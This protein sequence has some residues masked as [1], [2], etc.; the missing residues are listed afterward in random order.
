MKVT[1]FALI[2]TVAMLGLAAPARAQEAQAPAGQEAD[3]M[4]SDIVV[5][6]TRRGTALQNTPLAV[7]ALSGESL[8]QA[9]ITT[10][11]DLV[12]VA[13]TVQVA[14]VNNIPQIYIRGIGLQNTTIGSDPG[15]AVHINGAYLA[16]PPM[17]EAGMYDLERVEVLRGPQGTLYG[18]NATGGA[19]NLI[20][21]KPTDK[22]EASVQLEIGNYDHIRV[23]AMVSGPLSEDVG[24]RVAGFFDSRNGYSTNLVTNSPVGEPRSRAGRVTL[25]YA[26]AD[27][28]LTSVLTADYLKTTR[29]GIANYI[30]AFYPAIPN[31]YAP[32]PGGRYSS[33]PRKAYYDLDPTGMTKI[34]GVTLEN[35]FKFDPVTLKSLTAY[36]YMRRLYS[37]DVDATDLPNINN[38]V[39]FD[40]SETFTQEFQLLSNNS[41]AF[42]WLVGGFYLHEKARDAFDYDIR[43]TFG[44]APFVV[45]FTLLIRDAQKTDSYAAFGQLSYSFLPG[46]KATVGLR[47][48]YDK[49]SIAE[50]LN[51]P[52]FFST[53][54]ANLND[55]WS[56]LTPKFG[57]EYKADS[58]FIYAS[59]TRGFKAGGFNAGNPNQ[60][61]G[62]DPEYVWTYEAGLKRDWFGRLL[63][64]NLS[65]FRSEYSNLQVTQYLNNTSLL[66][67][68]GSARIDGIELETTLKPSSQLQLQGAFTYLDTKYK[69]STP[70][71]TLLDPVQ[72]IPVDMTGKRLPFAPKYAFTLNVNYVLPVPA[73]D[74]DIILN[75]S[76]AWRSKAFLDS[77]D[78]D[79]E[80]QSA[81]GLTDVRLSWQRSDGK[82][83]LAVFGRN[84]FDKD[85]YANALRG[86]VSV[87]GAVG[88]LGAPR[89]YGVQGRLTL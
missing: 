66:K 51:I 16:R 70:P 35:T 29:D 31:V 14:K 38:P 52:E 26:P 59:V 64:T 56:A 68:A 76:E 77:I 37:S 80:A 19:L 74:G 8:A 32:V 24:V 41:G 10:A 13:P 9:G 43:T 23:D 75:V 65:V 27:S 4:V 5:T 45:P 15:V 39:Q 83:E 21:A 17:M 42:E 28:V 1:R 62:Y 69:G 86:S 22:L 44:G 55:H 82:L 50:F 54:T 2:S 20:T 71:F 7:T 57:L 53:T 12:R 18:R 60:T 46:L 3:S 67:N 49:K 87:G 34:A 48:S 89:T 88:T 47:Y 63:R 73:L 85:Y 81:Y 30:K 40:R 72:N 58:T 36:R 25:K 11:A 33:D 79:T 6:A 78:R 84:I 61:V